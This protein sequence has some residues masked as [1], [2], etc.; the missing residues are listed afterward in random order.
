MEELS[1]DGYTP[2]VITLKDRAREMKSRVFDIRKS[3]TGRK[4]TV[5][6]LKKHGSRRSN[7]VR[8]KKTENNT[9]GQMTLFK[10][11]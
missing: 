5:D 6:V 3:A 7:A 2:K 11:L 10:T 1:L 9:E 4:I 8:R